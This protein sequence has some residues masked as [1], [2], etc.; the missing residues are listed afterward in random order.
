MA[1]LRP[2][3]HRVGLDAEAQAT[4]ASRSGHR[5]GFTTTYWTVVPTYCGWYQTPPHWL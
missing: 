4:S 3:A 1:V 2:N 5:G